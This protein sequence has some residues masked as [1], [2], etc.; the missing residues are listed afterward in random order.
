M[1]EHEKSSSRRGIRRYSEKG[2]QREETSTVHSF[3]VY[4]KMGAGQ[5]QVWT[6]VITYV[7]A[8]KRLS[9][10]VSKFENLCGLLGTQLD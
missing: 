9:Q 2:V 3:Y 1:A 6:R 5:G 4:L 8:S 10:I 7:L